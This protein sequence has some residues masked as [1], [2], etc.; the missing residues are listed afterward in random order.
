MS[1]IEFAPQTSTIQAS[2][3]NS[4]DVR[5]LNVV[6]FGYLVE[7]HGELLDIWFET[8]VTI[9]D[10]LNRAPALV[11]DVIACAADE[12]EQ[13]EKAASLPIGLQ[14]RALSEIFRLTFS[15]VDMG[16]VMGAFLAGVAQA[17]TRS[18]PSI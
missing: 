8:G 10:I 9:T 11:A 14:Y 1:F 5:G 2:N 13:S 4:F 6:D 17:P 7:Q 18:T 12:R 16:K 3:G 15:E